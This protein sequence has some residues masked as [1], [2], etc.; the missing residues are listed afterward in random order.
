[1]RSLRLIGLAV[2]ALPAFSSAIVWANTLTEAQ[3]NAFGAND[4]RFQGI[5]RVYEGNSFSATGTYIGFSNGFHWG[6]TAR[7]VIDAGSTGSFRFSNGQYN[8]TQVYNVLN[9]D[10]SVFKI[11]GWDRNV[12]T[13]LIRNDNSFAPGTDLVSAGYGLHGAQGN[14]PYQSDTTRRGMTSKI[15]RTEFRNLI[16]S[17]RLALIDRFDAPNDPRFTPFEGFGASGD[18]GSPLIDPNGR[19]LA[20]LTG[21]EFELYGAINWYSTITPDV[22]NEIQNITGVP[23][24][25][26]L[27]ALGAGLLAISRRRRSK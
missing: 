17:N 18:S 11:A 25:A 20:V 24:P 8:I 1:M 4:S 9:A 16:Y 7:H 3:V 5:G 22:A 10:V 13:P 15:E 12:W 2:L 23:E 27:I 26:T 6:L 14:S 19:V 21:G